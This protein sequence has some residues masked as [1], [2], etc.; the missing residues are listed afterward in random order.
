MTTTRAITCAV[1]TATA[2]CALHAHAQL[3]E[4][5]LN[6]HGGGSGSV[7][8]VRNGAIQRQWSGPDANGSLFITSSNTVR[9]AGNSGSP[10]EEFTLAGVPTGTTFPTPGTT[11]MHVDDSTTDGTFA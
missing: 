7:F 2:L 9:T 3:S 4:L 10:G 11:G 5:Y 1:A 8:V 6:E